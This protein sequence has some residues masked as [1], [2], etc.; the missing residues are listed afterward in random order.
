MIQMSHISCCHILYLIAF[1]LTD[2]F[3]KTFSYTGTTQNYE[4]PKFTEEP[5]DVY[6]EDG[7]PITLRCKATGK[8]AP[9]YKWLK[10]GKEM[11]LRSFGRVRLTGSNLYI[12]KAE[13]LEDVAKYQCLAKVTYLE[14]EFKIV[15]RSA[16]LKRA[17]TY[18]CSLVLLIV[19]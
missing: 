18:G 8:P 5:K 11:N 9:E 13:S 4:A 16:R 7:K 15:S 1:L 17:G 6:I 12:E 14:I 2:R 10:N 19:L 3:S